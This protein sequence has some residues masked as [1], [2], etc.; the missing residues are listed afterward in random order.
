[1]TPASRSLYYFGIYLL[2][3]GLTLIV[4]PNM[5]LSLIG[6][7]ETTEVWIRLL[8]TVV[9]AIGLYYVFMAPAN[10]PLFLMLS[11]YA[12]VSIFVWFLLF[13]ILG[14]G[15]MQLLIFGFVDLLG[16]LWTYSALRRA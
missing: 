6:I 2:F 12:R 10:H 9:T 4:F 14:I 8:G 15:P 11:V 3:T 13:V 5:L 16:A 7:P 1:M